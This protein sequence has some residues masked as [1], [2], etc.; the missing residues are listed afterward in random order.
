MNIDLYHE[1]RRVSISKSRHAY[2]LLL[3]T[4]FKE[5]EKSSQH[6]FLMWIFYNSTYSNLI[7]LINLYSFRYVRSYIIYNH[8]KPCCVSNV[9]FPLCLNYLLFHFVIVHTVDSLQFFSSTSLNIILTGWD[10]IQLEIYFIPF[11]Q[12]IMTL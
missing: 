10:I 4:S 8:C 5:K 1:N 2:H 9:A 6:C 11:S 12:S 3:I 7:D